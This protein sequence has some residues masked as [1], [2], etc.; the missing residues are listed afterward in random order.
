MRCP[1]DSTMNNRPCSP[2]SGEEG[3]TALSTTQI[4]CIYLPELPLL[5]HLEQ[6]SPQHAATKGFIPSRNVRAPQSPQTARTGEL[7]HLFHPP[8][9]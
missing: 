3:A 1:W 4:S 8:T 6:L 2:Q 9:L 5:N 7:R